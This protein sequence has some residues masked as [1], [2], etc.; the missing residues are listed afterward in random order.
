M[1]PN[2][3]LWPSQVMDTWRDAGADDS[4]GRSQTLTVGVQKPRVSFVQGPSMEAPA[5]AVFLLL[6][7]G[8]IT[9]RNP[10]WV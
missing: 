7:H 6:H 3:A 9:S 10:G 1:S 2:G 8:K 5:Q 4:A